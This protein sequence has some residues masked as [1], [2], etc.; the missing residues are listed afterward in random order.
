MSDILKDLQKVKSIFEKH[1]LTPVTLYAK[2]KG[3]TRQTVNNWVKNN[4]VAFVKF[5][6]T[7]FIIDK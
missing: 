6:F 3:V 4:K 1:N 5:G 7:T 2:R